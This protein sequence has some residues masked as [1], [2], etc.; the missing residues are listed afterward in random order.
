[1]MMMIL[2]GGGRK[3]RRSRFAIYMFRDFVVGE[4][5]SRNELKDCMR[6][7]FGWRCLSYSSLRSNDKNNAI[8][9]NLY[10]FLY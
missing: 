3:G 10:G 5:S 4:D 9:L 1:M 6:I 7:T 8:A 2:R